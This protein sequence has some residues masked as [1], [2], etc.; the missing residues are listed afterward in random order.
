MIRHSHVYLASIAFFAILFAAPASAEPPKDCSALGPAFINSPRD[1]AKCIRCSGGRVA[2]EARTACIAKPNPE[3]K[4]TG[5]VV[6]PKI[7]RPTDSWLNPQ[8]EPPMARIS[9]PPHTKS[10]AKG[11]ACIPQPK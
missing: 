9:C 7:K 1:A 2:N 11:T 8:P 5:V 6:N 3:R 4:G 10:N